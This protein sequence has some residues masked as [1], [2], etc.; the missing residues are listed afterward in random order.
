MKLP[1]RLPHERRIIEIY[2]GPETDAINEILSDSS[3]TKRNKAICLLLLE[4]E[5]RAVDLVIS[6]FLILIG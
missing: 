4:T 1:T 5:L 3:F 6:S 2:N